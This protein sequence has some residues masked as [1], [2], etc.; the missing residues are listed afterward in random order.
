ADFEVTWA[1]NSRAQRRLL[2]ADAAPEM[3]PSA[4]PAEKIASLWRSYDQLQPASHYRFAPLL[5]H[6][7]Q[8]RLL[9]LALA[10]RAGKGYESTVRSVFADLEKML[11]G[12][13]PRAELVSVASDNQ[14]MGSLLTMPQP[15]AAYSL[16]MAEYLGR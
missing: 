5:C 6:E 9:W 12:L 16:R 14:A 15:P 11:A 4:M 8:H 13:K 7:V 1:M 10:N 3:A 2:R